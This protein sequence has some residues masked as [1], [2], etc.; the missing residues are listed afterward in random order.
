MHLVMPAEFQF[1]STV[2]TAT[3]TGLDHGVAGCGR[4]PE[5]HEIRFDAVLLG[6]VLVAIASSH[7]P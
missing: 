4:S 1:E 6:L 2:C 7:L 5:S 3:M